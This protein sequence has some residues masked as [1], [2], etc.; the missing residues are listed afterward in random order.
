M[1]EPENTLPVENF[2]DYRVGYDGQ[3]WSCRPRARS[4]NVSD[5]HTIKPYVEANGRLT[6]TLF[7]VAG[8]NH[9]VGVAK[10]VMDAFAG[11]PKPGHGIIYKDGDRG[12]CHRDNL[13]YGVPPSRGS[14]A[15]GQRARGENHRDA[16]LS[17]E[18]VRAIRDR[19]AGGTSPKV[20]A[21]E[22]DVDISLI[23]KI[24]YKQIWKDV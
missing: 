16:K 20:L 18:G 4:A 8:K 6:V 23:Y 21:I 17:V 24:K 5:W 14:V 22:N 10:L 13:Y 2:P 9:K 11:P 1:S 15:V 3:V 19:L 12:N 7:Q